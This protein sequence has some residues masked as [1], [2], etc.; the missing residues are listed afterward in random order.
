MDPLADMSSHSLPKTPGVKEGRK[1]GR[2]SR[3]GQEECPCGSF[4]SQQ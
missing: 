2:V 3:E 4:L 1:E